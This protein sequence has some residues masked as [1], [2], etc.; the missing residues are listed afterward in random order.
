MRLQRPGGSSPCLSP[1]RRPSSQ[2][3]SDRYR[4]SGHCRKSAESPSCMHL[5]HSSEDRPPFHIGR[6]GGTQTI[7]GISN[8]L[9]RPGECFDLNGFSGFDS[10]ARHRFGF[11]VRGM[12]GTYS[13]VEDRWTVDADPG[14]DG[15][16]CVKNLRPQRAPR[17]CNAQA[18]S[19]DGRRSERAVG[20]QE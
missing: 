16:D 11:E 1:L 5:D 2:F 12:A 17:H 9:S 4:S 20:V 8:A 18:N 10:S 15:G 14:T 3:S 6:D 13:V 7:K 19:K